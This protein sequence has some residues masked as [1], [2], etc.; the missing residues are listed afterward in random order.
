VKRGG[1]RA[2]P[3]IDIEPPFVER[4]DARWNFEKYSSALTAIENAATERPQASAPS[5]PKTAETS[6]AEL[7]LRVAAAC[8]R[9]PGQGWK[10][11]AASWSASLRNRPRVPLCPLVGGWSSARRM[12]SL[13]LS[14]RGGGAR[15]SRGIEGAPFWA[16]TWAPFWAPTWAPVR[17]GGPD[18]STMPHEQLKS[19][20]GPEP[21]NPVKS[22]Y[23]LANASSIPRRERRVS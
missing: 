22:D 6:P 21:D 17:T 16:P 4:P 11:E 2:I 20:P 14:E 1:G 13:V 19:G 23:D 12:R 5:M 18:T 3:I 15:R 8:W 9:S 7:R 10:P